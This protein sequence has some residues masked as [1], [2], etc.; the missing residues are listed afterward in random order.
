MKNTNYKQ[1]RQR[2]KSD[3]WITVGVVTGL[4]VLTSSAFVHATHLPYG[5]LENWI[6]MPSCSIKQNGVEIPSGTKAL[7]GTPITFKVSVTGPSPDFYSVTD[8]TKNQYIG[9]SNPYTATYSAGTTSAKVTMVATYTYALANEG[10]VPYPNDTYPMVCTVALKDPLSLSNLGSGGLVQSNVQTLSPPAITDLTV[11]K[12]PFHIIT[13]GVSFPLTLSY[14][15]TGSVSSATINVS[16][17][18]SSSSVVKTW[19]FT[20]QVMGTKTFT[21]DGKNSANAWVTP[22]Q[23]TF[24][25]VGKDGIKTLTAKQL[26]FGVVK[27]ET[28]LGIN[29]KANTSINTNTN[30]NSSNLNE[31]LT[32]NQNSNPANYAPLNDTVTDNGAGTGDTA[33]TGDSGTD[34]DTGAGQGSG[35]PGALSDNFVNDQSQTTGDEPVDI[36]PAEDILHCF[37][38]NGELIISENKKAMIRCGLTKSALV[39]V[40]VVKGTY[41]PPK[42]PDPASIV[43]TIMYNDFTFIKVLNFNWDG[44]DA[45]DQ[46]SEEGDYSFV[47]SAKT[48]EGEK[49]DFSVK[50]FKLMY[51]RPPATQEETQ[52]QSDTST[53]ATEDNKTATEPAAPPAPQPSKCPG[54]NYPSD[55]TGHWAKEFIHAGYDICLFKGFKDGTFRPD[56][57]LRKVDAVKLVML[58]AGN[59][60]TFGCY[61]LDCGS[62]FTDL[63][64]GDGQW[65]RA[66]WDRKIIKGDEKSKFYPNK[67]ITRGEFSALLAKAFGIQPFKGC[68]TT[69]CGAGHPNN[70]FLDIAQSWQGAYLRSLWDRKIVDPSNQFIFRPEDPITRAEMAKMIM[71]A[72]TGTK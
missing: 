65:I 56:N 18:N 41:T 71:K 17:L 8:N 40:W 12:D 63:G 48:M 22:G 58:A 57:T 3:H 15:L 67:A 14:K 52:P 66:A 44:I 9:G 68:F 4:L 43:K 72:K 55:V 60:P 42:E 25:V 11:S 47:V 24:K 29:S 33:Y 20:N 34:Q 36:T 21:W 69:N 13:S 16:I 49:P 10:A 37:M 54:I 26:S 27:D 39:T 5:E 19:S 45:F 6:V 35:D 50:K 7:T 23:Y 51:Q 28:N 32:I 64:I 1:R 30:T 38:V 2:G 46:P 53:G 31:P 70:F 62:P 61:D 59:P